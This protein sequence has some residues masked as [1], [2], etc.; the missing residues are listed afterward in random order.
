MKK[1]DQP[2]HL[3]N[4][5]KVPVIQC[6]SEGAVLALWWWLCPPC[7]WNM[8][9]FGPLYKVVTTAPTT[10]TVVPITFAKLCIFFKLSL[11]NLI[12]LKT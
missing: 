1:L 8:S 5:N 6:S 12:K 3:A 7:P 10:V 9:R 11:S 4:S 2:P